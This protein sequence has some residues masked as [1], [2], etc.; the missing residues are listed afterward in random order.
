M[1][2][3]AL[4]VYCTPLITFATVMYQ[5]LWPKIFEALS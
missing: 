2:D 1:P 3:A 4:D 5:P